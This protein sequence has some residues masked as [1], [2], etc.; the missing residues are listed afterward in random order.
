MCSGQEEG[1]YLRERGEHVALFFFKVLLLVE[2][3]SLITIF[4]IYIKS[5]DTVKHHVPK[6]FITILVLNWLSYSAPTMQNSL[7]VAQYG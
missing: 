6:S 2:S 3:L 7:A 1:G 4:A 5:H